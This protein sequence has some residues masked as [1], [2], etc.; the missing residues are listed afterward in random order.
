MSIR[1]L[2]EQLINQIAAGEVI[3]RPASVVKELVENSLDAGARSIEV[4]AERGGI[5]RM[6]VRDDGCGIGKAELSLALARHA[7]SKIAALADLERVGTLG[8]RGEALP[9][10]GSVA[11]LSLTS[12]ARGAED[13]WHI[14]TDGPGGLSEPAPAAHADGATVEVR[15]LFF[16]VPARRKFLRTEVTEFGHLETV[17]RRLALSHYDVRWRLMHNGR[18]VWRLPPCD[19]R[20]A[21]EA[22]IATL[23]GGDFVEHTLYI[24][25][26]RGGVGLRG[27]IGLPTAARART[28][29]QYFYVNGRMVRDKLIAHAVR[30]AYDDVLFHGRHPSFVLYLDID[31]ALVD[32]N[33]HPAKH[34]VRFRDGRRVHDQIF[35]VLHEALATTR[36]KTERP[37]FGPV[38]HADHSEGLR[39]RAPQQVRFAMPER[40]GSVA[41]SLT[42]Y[43]RLSETAAEPA[44]AS[45]PVES[46][47]EPP[48]GIA[49]GQYR[50][51]YILAQR[52]DGLVLIDMHAAHER[53]TY[54]QMKRALAN[55]GISTAPLLVPVTVD[56]TAAE[57]E[58]L[59]EAAGDL[60]RLGLEV[61]RLGPSSIAVRSLPLELRGADAAALVR[62]IAADLIA[63]GGSKGLSASIERVLAT[64]ACHRAVRAGRQ[65][66]LAEM[67]ALLRAMEKTD[68]A[69]QCNHGRPTWTRLSLAELDR[70]FLRGQ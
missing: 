43:A 14:R 37:S 52:S 12:R 3:E 58:Q 69:D 22:R 38:A 19:D 21:S 23:C 50:G 41:E 66:T 53:V 49:I 34:E 30:Q 60:A 13:A 18:E 44:A 64:L 1:V 24:E 31:P 68:R 59:A 32:V 63:E 65:L 7:T 51:I 54:E 36:P 29:R 4:E 27:W 62:E 56:L 15:E 57:V 9:S 33:A 2:P 70:L 25:H 40:T 28:D 67:N 16:S 6:L 48:L 55:G 11:E 42:A 8:F 5:T 35:H 17:V 20:A 45:E 10:I 26:E 46:G 61:D 47:D 39:E